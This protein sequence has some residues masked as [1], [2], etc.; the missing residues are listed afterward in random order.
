MKRHKTQAVLAGCI[1]AAI[2]SVSASAQAI[3]QLCTPKITA[4]EIVASPKQ[5]LE[6]GQKAS[7]G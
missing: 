6:A 7:F 3:G 4:N 5:R 2:A 1:M